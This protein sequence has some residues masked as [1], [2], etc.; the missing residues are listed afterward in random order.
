[1]LDTFMKDILL[2]SRPFEYLNSSELETLLPYCKIVSFAPNEIIIKQGNENNKMYFII[3]GE[4]I[5]LARVL[6]KGMIPISN[7]TEGDFFGEISLIEQEVCTET[8]I[9]EKNIQ[10]IV[11]TS[12]YF[13]TLSLIFPDIKYKITRSILEIICERMHRVFDKIKERLDKS[14]ISSWYSFNEMTQSYIKTKS[15]AFS[16]LSIDQEQLYEIE[17]FTQFNNKDFNELLNYA[18]LVSAGTKH[19]LMYKDDQDTSSYIIIH[20]ALEASI[21]K[22]DKRVKLAIL[23]PGD[24]FGGITYCTGYPT[25]ISYSTRER[26]ILLEFKASQLKKLKKNNILVWYQY[27]NLISHSIV[28]MEKAADKLYIRLNSE[29]V[30]SE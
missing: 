17:I 4:A 23:S 28:K 9:A 24:L 13:D 15:I 18:K 21:I 16:D 3:E 8:V 19:T 14:V 6:G 7:L 30:V 12:H 22:D 10:C 11:M 5:A 20:G 2:R 25:A 26:T 1:M 27:Y 29:I